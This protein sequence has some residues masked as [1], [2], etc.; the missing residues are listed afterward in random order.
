MAGRK[1]PFAPELLQP[2][3]RIRGGIDVFV[4]PACSQDASMK[5]KFII[6][7]IAIAMPLSAQAQKTGAAKVTKADVEKGRQ[8]HQR[9]Q[10]QDADYYDMANLNDQIE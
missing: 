7:V 5:L 9:R 2:I 10:G 4:P 3:I 1:T 8:D 6:V